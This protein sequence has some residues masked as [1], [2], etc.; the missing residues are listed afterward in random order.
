[1][2]LTLER[3]YSIGGM[4]MYLTLERTSS[5]GGMYMHLTLDCGPLLWEVC[6]CILH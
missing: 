2:Y 4:Y 1:M 6:T 3:T 5:M